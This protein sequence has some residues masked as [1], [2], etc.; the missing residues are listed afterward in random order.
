LTL[1]PDTSIQVC[2]RLVVQSGA[3][4]IEDRLPGRQGRV[5]F[6]YL[7]LHRTR[8]VPA[9]ELE[10]ALWPDGETAPPN[11]S[12]TLRTLVS[13]TR[14]AV[15][16]EVLG[17]GPLYRLRLPTGVRV[18]LESATAAL[19]DAEAAI[20]AE[21][22]H[23]AWGPSQVALFTARRGFLP[24]EDAPWIEEQRRAL[25]DLELRALECYASA[26]LGVGGSELPGAERS[27][28]R[29]VEREPYRESGYRLLMRA[30]AER[31]NVAEALRTFDR[32]SARLREDLGA[33]PSPESRA[34]QA[35]LLRS[36]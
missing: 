10:T 20:A 31:G 35:E 13:K 30:L 36:T 25:G 24:G 5:L 26:A 7:V 21:D 2:G 4:R 16:A 23:R 8:D 6:A 32:L 14:A 3:H 15:G 9:A 17:R 28:R 19:H 11:A 33:D 1:D 12:A 27:A 29:L 34:L 18:D 22:W